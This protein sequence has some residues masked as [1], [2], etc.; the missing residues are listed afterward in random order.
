MLNLSWLFSN[1]LDISINLNNFKNNSFSESLREKNQKNKNIYEI[2]LLFPLLI[3]SLTEIQSL[4]VYMTD[5][6]QTELDFLLK[7]EKY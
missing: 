1:I 6:F 2:I 5:S 3:C 7:S 4:K